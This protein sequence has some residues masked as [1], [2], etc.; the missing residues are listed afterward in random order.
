M[1]DNNKSA[2]DQLV[3][4]ALANQKSSEKENSNNLAETLQSLQ[5]IIE[6]NAKMLVD[7]DKQLKEKRE[8]MKNIFENDSELQECEKQAKENNTKLKEKKAQLNQDTQVVNAKLEVNELN[9]QKKEIEETLSTH[10]LSYFQLTNSKSFD[11]SDGDQWDFEIK[12][13]VK[14]K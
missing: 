2:V 13:K 11:T 6:N 1:S 12:A 3:N 4:Q 10:L 7:L 8:I 5:G 9:E 14:T